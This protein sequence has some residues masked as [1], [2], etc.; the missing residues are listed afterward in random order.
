MP[1]R[2]IAGFQAVFDDADGLLFD[3]KKSPGCPEKRQAWKKAC[4]G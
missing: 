2:R 3:M 1:A 4:R